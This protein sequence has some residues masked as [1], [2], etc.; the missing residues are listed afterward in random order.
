MRADRLGN[1]SGKKSPSVTLTTYL[2]WWLYFACRSPD[3]LLQVLLV[4][5]AQRACVVALLLRGL[6]R[7]RFLGKVEP[8]QVAPLPSDVISGCGPFAG[9]TPSSVLRFR[10]KHS[11]SCPF[12]PGPDR[13]PREAFC[14]AGVSGSHDANDYGFRGDAH[15]EP[16]LGHW[17]LES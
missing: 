15:A 3:L 6:Q 2:T 11:E 1:W 10:R 7:P 4:G 9:S 16:L 17:P 14:C 12:W 13:K 8:F 5:D